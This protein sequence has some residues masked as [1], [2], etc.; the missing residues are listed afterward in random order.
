M[1][2]KRVNELKTNLDGRGGD[3]RQIG[4]FV[5]FGGPADIIDAALISV[6]LQSHVNL[7]NLTIS[8]RDLEDV[9]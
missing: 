7:M 4:P 6:P 2:M 3:L 5:K 8:H 9:P 1:T